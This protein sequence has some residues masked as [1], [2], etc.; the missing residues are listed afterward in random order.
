MISDDPPE[1]VEAPVTLA[2]MRPGREVVEDYGS[3][4]LSLRR[5]PLAFLRKELRR[6][7]MVTCADLD[8]VRNGRRVVVAAD[9]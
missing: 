9:W 4:G 2:P 3:T 6:Q 5:H 8:R 1:M 7:G